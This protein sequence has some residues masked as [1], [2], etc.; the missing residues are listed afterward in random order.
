M[1][2]TLISTELEMSVTRVVAITGCDSGLGWAIA[3]RSAREGIITVAGMYQGTDTGAA[4]ALK[5]LRAHPYKLD[6][7][8]AESVA[9]FRNY[10]NC[11]LDDNPN[12]STELF[13]F[14]FNWIFFIRL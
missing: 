8:D 5:K 1:L 4:E 6:V 9:G 12:Y 13:S 14:L 7:T 11:L 2:K 10:V 3:A